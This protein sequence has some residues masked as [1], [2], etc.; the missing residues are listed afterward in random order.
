MMYGQPLQGG[1]A[2]VNRY[3]GPLG[4]AGKLVGL[5]RDELQAGIPGWAYFGL[6]CMAGGTVAFLLRG[7]LSRLVGDS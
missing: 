7:K 2:M 6:G 5:G 3:G 4:L 1:I